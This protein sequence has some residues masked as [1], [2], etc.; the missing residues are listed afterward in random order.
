MNT[1]SAIAAAVEA[2]PLG[3]LRA[4]LVGA[5]AHVVGGWVR[6]LVAG[7]D[8][9]GDLDIAVEGELEALLDDLD[10]DLE[11]DE[12]EVHERHRRFGSATVAVGDLRIDLTRTRREVYVRPGALPEVEPATI[13]EDLRRRDFTVNALAVPLSAAGELLDPFDGVTDLQ[14]GTLRALHDGSFVDDP[15]RAIRA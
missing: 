14:A 3:P 15:T 4:P 10:P 5:G 7:R 2:L 11:V 12:V 13:A 6:E 9:G 8:P 1:D